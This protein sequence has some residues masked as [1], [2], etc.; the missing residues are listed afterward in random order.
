MSDHFR[1]APTG[2]IRTKTICA[3]ELRLDLL[4]SWRCRKVK[5]NVLLRFDLRESGKAYEV[6]E[7]SIRAGVAGL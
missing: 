7:Q 2:I 3:R 5:P 6:G 4:L 1:D